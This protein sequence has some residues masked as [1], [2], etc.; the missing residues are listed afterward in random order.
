MCQ[1]LVIIIEN[2]TTYSPK[3]FPCGRT[4]KWEV[5]LVRSLDMERRCLLI[6]PALAE[7]KE[8]L[9][10]LVWYQAVVRVWTLSPEK[11]SFSQIFYVRI[12]KGKRKFHFEFISEDSPYLFCFDTRESAWFLTSWILGLCFHFVSLWRPARIYWRRVVGISHLQ[13]NCKWSWHQSISSP[14]VTPDPKCGTGMKT[15]LKLSLCCQTA[16]GLILGAQMCSVRYDTC[17]ASS[18]SPFFFIFYTLKIFLHIMTYV[19]NPKHLLS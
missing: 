8:V 2:K 16:S 5:Y 9:I 11:D 3:A 13:K 12:I 4:G 6:P 18:C 17:Q 15:R 1:G 10:I 14:M 19:L 7:Q